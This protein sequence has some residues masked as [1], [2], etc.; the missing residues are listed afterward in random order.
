MSTTESD[1]KKYT[2]P[3]HLTNIRYPYASKW[4]KHNYSVEFEVANIQTS[5]ANAIR[6]L[7]ISDVKTVGFRTEPYTACDIQVLANDTPLHN[8]FVLHRLSMIPIYIAHPDKFDSDDYVF[9]IDMSNNTNMIINITS[10]DFQ[11]KRISTNKF[12]PKSEVIKFFPPNPITGDYILIN[13]LRPKYF[14]PSKT[15][16]QEVVDDMG[17]TFKKKTDDIMHFHIEGKA[18]ISNSRENGHY[19]PVSCATY[20]NTVDPERASLG[21]KEYIDKM[22]E[23][24]KTENVTPMTQAQLTRRFELTERARFFYRNNKDEPNVFTFKIETIGVI[25]SLIIFHRSIDILKEKINAFVSHLINKNEDIITIKASE[26]LSGGYDIIV[27]NE[28]DTLGN[29]IQTHLCLLYADYLIPKDERKLKFIGYKR[30]HPL[31]KHIIIAIQGNTDNIDTIINEII[32][33]GCAQIVKVL[34]KIQNE[35]ESTQQF[36]S[37]LKRIN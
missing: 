16:S 4:D 34:N 3:N 8:Q 11:I 2:K 35:L 23:T 13:K 6:R 30:P 1:K 18:S 27:K 26:Q 28:D 33:P 10:E 19:S 37:E 9:I 14:V 12:L 15:V 22:I 7:M 21:L 5:M 32:K 36:I 20:I 17:K 25:P 31:E 29:I 24:A